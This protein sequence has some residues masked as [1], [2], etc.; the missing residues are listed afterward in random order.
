MGVYVLHDLLYKCCEVYIDDMLIFGTDD[1]DFLSN[2]RKVFQRCR[3]KYVT[4]N[5][6]KLTIGK[7]KVSFIGHELDLQGIKNVSQKRLDSATRFS[8][9]STLKDLQSS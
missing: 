7:D 1:D 3:E 6:K 5:S 2:V 8:K 4:L 9:P